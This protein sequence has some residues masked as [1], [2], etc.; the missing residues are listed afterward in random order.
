MKKIHSYISFILLGLVAVM[1]ACTTPSS[2]NGQGGSTTASGNF[3][4]ILAGSSGYVKAYIDPVDHNKDSFSLYFDSDQDGIDDIVIHVKGTDANLNNEFT[5]RDGTKL[6]LLKDATTGVFTLKVTI[7]GHEVV[8]VTEKV[9]NAGSLVVFRGEMGT[10]ESIFIADD[11]GVARG[12]VDTAASKAIPK[13]VFLNKVV[14]NLIIDTITKKIKYVIKGISV[15]PS[16][17]GYT[18]KQID[19]INNKLD[20]YADETN[21]GTG[22]YDPS[23]KEYILSLKNK[24][25]GRVKLQPNGDLV[26]SRF[27]GVLVNDSRLFGVARLR[28]NAKKQDGTK[29][30]D[31]LPAVTFHGEAFINGVKIN[32]P[33]SYTLSATSPEQDV[34]DIHNGD[35]T[36]DPDLESTNKKTLESYIILRRV[37]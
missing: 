20:K 36:T 27:A 25:L 28:L 31:S 8:T 19:S 32:S 7:P 33:G 34:T 22:S 12:Q 3:A 16:H 11:D 10:R 23:T 14:F 29:T 35:P 30:Q 5:Y 26:Q 37:K 4:S 15:D 2:G 21:E 9:E 1:S 18:Q 6:Q 13:R 17:Y 24:E